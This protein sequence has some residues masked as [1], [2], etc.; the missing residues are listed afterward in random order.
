MCGT[1]IIL[2]PKTF[3]KRNGMLTS[4]PK[5][6]S[7][8]EVETI[9]MSSDAAANIFEPL[10]FPVTSIVLDMKGETQSDEG[11]RQALVQVGAQAKY[12]TP[13]GT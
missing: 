12:G 2:Q 3:E 1:R 8:T 5:A 13:I 7:R 10:P 6:P 9:R 11:L 4:N